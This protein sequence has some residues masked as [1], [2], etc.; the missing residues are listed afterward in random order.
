MADQ[1][2]DVELMRRIAEALEAGDELSAEQRRVTAAAL[3]QALTLPP[4]TFAERDALIVECRRRFFPSR[5]DHDAA[6]EIAVTWRRYA[7]T[8]WLRERAAETCPPRSVGTL[9]GALWEIMRI[10]PRVL[11]VR[12]IRRIVGHL[13]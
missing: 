9:R 13:K 8:G 6:Q 7:A 10:L 11:S 3:R 1:A 2:D 4:T 5:T 12:Q